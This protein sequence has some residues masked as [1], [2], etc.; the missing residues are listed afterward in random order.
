M[1]LAG[2]AIIL[3]IWRP[4]YTPMSQ[5][6]YIWLV[7]KS[8]LHRAKRRK[9]V[10]GRSKSL[11]H[12]SKSYSGAKKDLLELTEHVTHLS[13]TSGLAPRPTIRSQSKRRI[14]M[15]RPRSVVVKLL[16][17]QYLSDEPTIR[18]IDD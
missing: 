18:K 15:H 13:H 10:S 7:G 5:D 8:H 12:M 16:A 6:T 14:W 17:N 4:I 2:G 1:P 9:T 11:R 3:L